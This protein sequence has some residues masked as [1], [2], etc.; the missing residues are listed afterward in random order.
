MSG[1]M[2]VFKRIVMSAGIPTT[3]SEINTKWQEINEAEGTL[4]SNNSEYSPF[5][6]LLNAIVT[7]CAMYFVDFIPSHLMPECFTRTASGEILDLHA[8]DVGLERKPATTAI[9]QITFQ[10]ENVF[11]PLT[12]PAGVKIRSVP[13]NGNVYELTTTTDAVFPFD[14]DK[15]IAAVE[16]SGSGTPYN[17]AAGYYTVL[18]VPV[19]GV[20]EVT[21]APDWLTV[22]GTDGEEDESLR[23]RIRNQFL[24]VNQYHTDAVYRT[25]IAQFGNIRTDYIYF[26]HDAPRG[27]GT[28]NAYILFDVDDPI[29][30]FVDDINRHVND[31]GYHGHGDDVRCFAMPETEHHISVKVWFDISVTDVYRPVLIADIRNFIKCAFRENT[32]YDNDLTKVWPQSTF[33]FSRL[34]REL[35]N[36]FHEIESLEFSNSDINSAMSIPRIGTLVVTQEV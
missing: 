6:R 21:N 17:L 10:R 19:T 35:H 1:N 2:D 4:I 13:I 32:D 3:E 14:G 15:A 36:R 20:T 34:A 29:T 9:G 22:P 16:A 7:K 8:W 33:S 27:P 25:V 12:V 18:P 30:D 31:D 26:E 5:W 24:A 23:Q 11:D 28:A